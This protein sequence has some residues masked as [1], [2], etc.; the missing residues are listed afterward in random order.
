M[1]TFLNYFFRGILVAFPLVVTVYI[2]VLALSW[3]NSFFNSLFLGWFDYS[4]PGMGILAGILLIALFGLLVT[5]T[6]AKP[7]VILF[8]K[9]IRKMPIISII[10]TSLTDLTEA[11]VGDKKKFTAPVRMQ[12]GEG[13]VFRFGFITRQSLVEFDLGDM[14]AVYCPHSYNFSGNLYVVPRDWV[15]PIDTD[16]TE[17]MRFIVS[18]GVTTMRKNENRSIEP[19]EAPTFMD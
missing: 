12:M 14:V 19:Q 16:P 8:E 6:F 9:W 1:K 2:V 11:F 13:G 3:L 18:G 17:F 4:L 10:Y 7:L 15:T 5:Q